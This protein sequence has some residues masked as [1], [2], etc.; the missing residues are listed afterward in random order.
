MF[1]TI[2]L[3]KISF[4]PYNYRAVVADVMLRT[5]RLH[6]H[7]NFQVYNAVPITILTTQYIRLVSLSVMGR[8]LI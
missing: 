1:V 5:L 2:K 7:S 8:Y 6:S 4:T 3:D